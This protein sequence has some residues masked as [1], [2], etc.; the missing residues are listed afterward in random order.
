MESGPCNYICNP[1]CQYSSLKWLTAV[2]QRTINHLT[3]DNKRRVTQHVEKRFS[4]IDLRNLLART[5]AS[6]EIYVRQT[7]SRLYVLMLDEFRYCLNDKHIL[8]IP[9]PITL[10]D[11]LT[12]PM[13]TSSAWLKC[14]EGSHAAL[15]P[16]VSPPAF[17]VRNS[18][19]KISL[20]VSFDGARQC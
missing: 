20:M 12:G 2:A 4:I 15:D 8:D 18:V 10:I 11:F 16:L 1:T 7:Y 6:S 14:I 9:D 19:L 17:A 3:P 13:K 5:S